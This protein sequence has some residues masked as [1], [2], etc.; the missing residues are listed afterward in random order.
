MGCRKEELGRGTEAASSSAVRTELSEEAAAGTTA[1]GCDQWQWLMINPANV[2]CWWQTQ[3]HCLCKWLEVRRATVLKS[4][5]EQNYSVSVR[6]ELR[7]ADCRAFQEQRSMELSL[8]VSRAALEIG[9]FSLSH[10]N[11][12]LQDRIVAKNIKRVKITV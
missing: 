2:Y 8:N 3:E 10:R 6:G 7:G 1:G 5:G 11:S 4:Q 9:T 12:E